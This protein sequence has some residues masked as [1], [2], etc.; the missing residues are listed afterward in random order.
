MSDENKKLDLDVSLPD[1]VGDINSGIDIGVEV[2]ENDVGDIS[3]ESLGVDLFNSAEEVDAKEDSIEDIDL[4]SILTESAT[5]TD[6]KDEVSNFD[7]FSELSDLYTNTGFSEEF[8]DIETQNFI[9]ALNTTLQIRSNPTRMIHEPRNTN[10]VGRYK[11]KEYA[12]VITIMKGVFDAVQKYNSTLDK[13]MLPHRMRDKVSAN[14]LVQ[15]DDSDKLVWNEFY[16]KVSESFN[17]NTSKMNKLNQDISTVRNIFTSYAK[18]YENMDEFHRS[19]RERRDKNYKIASKEF[20]FLMEVLRRLESGDEKVTL[21][22]NLTFKSDNDYNYKFKCGKCKE[23]CDGATEIISSIDGS[24]IKEGDSHTFHQ[25]LTV[26]PRSLHYPLVCE[27]CGAINI[28]STSTRRLID[29]GIKK[30]PTSSSRDMTDY[31]QQNNELTTTASF[32]NRRHMS[33]G[34][35]MDVLEDKLVN[36]EFD[37]DYSDLDLTQDEILDKEFY[38][39]S[40]DEVDSDDNL[41][42]EVDDESYLSAIKSFRQRNDIINCM[43]SV[44]VSGNDGIEGALA[45]LSANGNSTFLSNIFGLISSYIVNTKT[46]AELKSVKSDMDYEYDRY[47]TILGAYN[48]CNTGEKVPD[49]TIKE[50]EDRFK[51]NY[52]L[53]ALTL[54]SV[55]AQ[56]DYERAKVEYEK[57]IDKMFNNI[58]LFGYKSR[59]NKDSAIEE[60]SNAFNKS[61]KFYDFM[62]YALRETIINS[63]IINI[64][65][66]F[67]YK[68]GTKKIISD[69]VRGLSQIK[70]RAHLKSNKYNTVREYMS[71]FIK[72][73]SKYSDN[74]KKLIDSFNNDY[75]IYLKY[76]E[77]TEMFGY[78]ADTNISDVITKGDAVSY[79]DKTISEYKGDIKSFTLVGD[80]KPKFYDTDYFREIFGECDGV[81]KQDAIRTFNNLLELPN[82]GIYDII[83]SRLILTQI[84]F[85]EFT[86]MTSMDIASNIKLTNGLVMRYYTK[87][88]DVMKSYLSA[89]SKNIYSFNK[90]S[91]HMFMHVMNSPDN[92]ESLLSYC[93]SEYNI[94][95]S[96]Y[97]QKS[98]VCAELEGAVDLTDNI[99]MLEQ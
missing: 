51:V 53:G 95:D 41:I 83:F 92:I 8:I 78:N 54:A 21:C 23:L 64:S 6:V 44:E 1:I 46:F 13:N 75:T 61:R 24:T 94:D 79:Y 86:G 97:R 12:D 27:H 19:M 22:N 31:R 62:I 43:K 40:N 14:C 48:M 85:N 47:L 30:E 69:N 50:F 81:I 89:S 45:L 68:V 3:F 74:I 93:S 10:I 28:M 34:K 42:S 29:D 4:F 57:V 76:K 2:I 65:S 87:E 99:P 52:E 59:E 39:N 84:S 20:A 36:E 72:S 35:W 18:N 25:V 60:V 17:G 26:G 66:S 90:L 98:Y 55:E 7:S 63:S 80:I 91:S 33:K 71:R 82:F 77:W 9:N 37:V 16:R 73:D 49:Y 67:G 38:I 88:L 5:D 15:Y 32:G 56:R 58:K 96:A 11:S 70:D